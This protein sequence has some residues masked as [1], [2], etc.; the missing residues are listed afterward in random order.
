MNRVWPSCF[1]CAALVMLMAAPIFA[2]SSLSRNRIVQFDIDSGVRADVA[3]G[4]GPG[5]VAMQVWA[6]EVHVPGAPWMR[7]RFAPET[8]LAGEHMH[9]GGSYILLT[10]AHDG[11][12]QWLDARSL[13]EWDNLSAY[14]IGDTVFV[15]FYAAPGMGDSRV[16]ITEAIVGLGGGVDSPICGATD[17]RTPDNDP[18]VARL[19][20]DF[21]AFLI[22]STHAN[23]FLTC[24]WC[25]SEGVSG[26]VAMFNIPPDSMG[27]PN[28]RFQFPV[29]ADSIRSTHGGI[30]GANFARFM[31]NSNS[32]TRLPAMIA[33]GRDYFIPGSAASG[34]TT[35]TTVRGFGEY[36]QPHTPPVPILW[37]LLNKVHTGPYA[38]RVGNRLNYTVDTFLGDEGGPVTQVIGTPIATE[39]V[40]GIHVSGDCPS[41]VNSG[42]A[43]DHGTLQSWITQAAGIPYPYSTSV[44]KALVTTFNSNNGGSMGGAVYFDVTVGQRPIDITHFLL[45]IHHDGTTNN[46]TPTK[47]DDRFNFSVFLT[48]NT[49]EGKQNDQSQWTLVASGSGMPRAQDARTLGALTS[50]PFRLSPF[51]SYG[52]AIAFLPGGGGHRYTNS[53]G[54]NEVYSNADLTIRCISASNVPFT[55][56]VP[57]RV[58]NG[59]IGYLLPKTTGQCKETF[60]ARDNSLGDGSTIF[61]NLRIK[62]RPLVLTRI[63]TNLQGFGG[64]NVQAR[65]YTTP[66]HY[67]GKETNPSAWTLVSTASGVSAPVDT[68]TNLPLDSFVNLPERGLFGFAIQITGGAHA[69]TNMAPI[70][71]G[72]PYNGLIEGADMDISGGSVISG[73]FSGTLFHQRIWNGALCYGID[74]GGC[75]ASLLAQTPPN[76]EIGGLNSMAAGQELA[77]DFIADRGLRIDRA[78]AWGAYAN[79]SEPPLFQSMR[80]T[81]YRDAGGLPGAQ[82]TSRLVNNATKI[83][84]GLMMAGFNKPIYQHDLVFATP[85]ELT[86]GRYWVSV[87]GNTPSHTWAWARLTTSANAHAVRQGT[88][89]WT[90][91]P[92]N[93]AWTLCGEELESC[94]ADCDPSTGP[95]VLDIFDFLCFGNHFAN[96]NTYACNCDL[97]TGN[98]VCDIFDFLCFGNAFAAG[99]P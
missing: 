35:A 23:E 63:T 92:G 57:N 79:M 83:D 99:C 66:G 88:G 19:N 40:V 24:G 82:V 97:S 54:T 93:F 64:Q 46:S 59:A 95:G 61:F 71:F 4:A 91:G 3:P 21:T 5:F 39:R 75:T 20:T 9:V 22:G 27:I 16:K 48:P 18:R 13:D 77:D 15:E 50:A 8:F 89:A 37:R 17:D 72:S 29:Q 58:W 7:L 96:N 73:L 84:T 62:D 11:D 45:N 26:I 43:T 74:L 31:T 56:N 14:F 69:Y 68:P 1:V 49:A 80:V 28:T 98:N 67:S 38:G 36:S 70:Q 55:G 10:S 60:F 41:G 34:G 78:T 90:P 42:T 85:V 52:M 94:Y 51:Q 53:V 25:V 44:S 76:S 47:M 81:F 30:P 12:E 65:L 2:Q 87:L 32:H 86:P 33:Q 6:T